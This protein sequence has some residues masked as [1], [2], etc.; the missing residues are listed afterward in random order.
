MAYISNDMT[1]SMLPKGGKFY[2]WH[3]EMIIKS[4]KKE[5]VIEAIYKFLVWYNQYE[6]D[7]STFKKDMKKLRDELIEQ[8]DREPDNQM[9]S[10]L[11]GK[12]AAIDD[13]LKLE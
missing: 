12:I 3:S 13:L 8:L 6:K 4:S 9:Q 2:F 5:A 1:R 10:Y 7:E 11:N